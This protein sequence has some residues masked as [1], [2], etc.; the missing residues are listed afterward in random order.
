[1]YHGKK[2]HYESVCSGR[3]RFAITAPLSRIFHGILCKNLAEVINQGDI[4]LPGYFS[5]KGLK[6]KL[7]QKNWNVYAKSLFSTAKELVSLVFELLEK[8][9]FLP[10]FVGLNGMEIYQEISGK[11]NNTKPISAGGSVQLRFI[12]HITATR[13]ILATCNED[14]KKVAN[15][16][17]L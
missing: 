15:F 2:A 11:R 7:Y 9:Q 8:S 17:T 10:R 16:M 12:S 4:F 14:I 1:L 13:Y 5:W 3:R 6:D